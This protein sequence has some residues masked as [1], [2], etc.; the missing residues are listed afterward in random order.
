MLLCTAT[1]FADEIPQIYGDT[2]ECNSSETVSY[3]VHIAN[4]PG[5]TSYLIGVGC[6]SDWL[7]FD[8]EAALGNFS[9]AGTITSSSDDRSVY[10]MWYNVDAVS[11]DGA[12]FTVNVHVS[13]STPDGEYPIIL[14]YSSE[15]TLDAD[16]NELALNTVNGCIKVK[17]VAYENVKDMLENPDAAEA[18]NHLLRIICISL[19]AAAMAAAVII[20]KRNRKK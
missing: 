9:D 14:A 5:I 7:Y 2:I 4:N 16:C 8:E 17:H 11:D 18:D 10:A 15:N 1:V 19:G 6:E 20:L 12:L 3:S 13:P